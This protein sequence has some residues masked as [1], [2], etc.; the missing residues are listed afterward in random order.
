M[1][2]IRRPL[3]SLHPTADPTSIGKYQLLGLL[4]AGGFGTVYLGEDPEGHLYAI[5]VAHQHLLIHDPSFR[6]R[7]RHEVGLVQRVSS[8]FAPRL[9]ATDL[10]VDQPWMATEFIDG[11]NLREAVAERPLEPNLALAI[12]SGMAH[13][14]LDIHAVGV[15]HRDLKPSN[16]I[17]GESGPRV[18]DFGIARAAEMTTLTAT[19]GRVGTAGY[20]SPEQ[21]AGEEATPK[22]DVFSWACTVC[23]AVT[24]RSPFG[25][26]HQPPRAIERAVE[27]GKPDIPELPA[28]LGPLVSAAL[29]PSPGE[30]PTAEEICSAL[31]EVA[32]LEWRLPDHLLPVQREVPRPAPPTEVTPSRPGEQRSGRAAVLVVLLLA[33]SLAAFLTLRGGSDETA[34][35]LPGQGAEI[36]TAP[37]TAPP[38]TAPAE[39]DPPGSSPTTPSVQPPD[40]PEPPPLTP[41]QLVA[42]FGDAVWRVEASGCDSTA[43]GSAFVIDSHHLVT[44]HHVIS[45]DARPLLRSRDNKVLQGRVIGATPLPDI[46]VIEVSE[47]IGQPLTWAQTDT[48]RVGQPVVALGYPGDDGDFTVNQGLIVSFQTDGTGRVAARTD[49]AID[50]GNS[51]GPGLTSTGEVVGVV[52][53]MAAGTT[54]QDVPLLYTHDYLK[55]TINQIL[56]DEPGYEADCSLGDSAQPAPTNIT[57][58]PAE[59][60]S[61]GQ[62]RVV[63]EWVPSATTTSS[64]IAYF[65]IDAVIE[66]ADGELRYGTGATAGPDETSTVVDGLGPATTYHFYVF[67]VGDD[68]SD[69][70]P[71]TFCCVA[72][73]YSATTTT[74]VTPTTSQLSTTTA[75]PTTRVSG[76]DCA[77]SATNGT[78][79]AA[80]STIDSTGTHRRA[81]TFRCRVRSTPHWTAMSIVR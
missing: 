79:T 62:F 16:V 53:E 26:E 30:R 13:A 61:A 52:T 7:F 60:S 19:G 40:S 4:G 38:P 42:E 31:E 48:L 32:P 46:A 64:Q 69:S 51:G 74:T 18:I 11:W 50:T 54:Y 72:T 66:G 34:Q 65:Q 35:P 43:S 9:S 63:V 28:P 44:N 67:A 39:A 76:S 22:S 78:S 75:A 37:S 57:V 70:N 25:D 59:P 5:K 77:L 56:T 55:G 68:G 24:G 23:F 14:L 71:G 12:A 45:I 1:V 58:G 8:Q 20:G 6:E 49:A 73:S 29:S 36:E 10:V 3:R 80:S 17:L 81:R 41:E 47:D 27:D 2:S 21:V 33:G 15:V